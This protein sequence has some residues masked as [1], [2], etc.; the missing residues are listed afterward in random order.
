[1]S[2]SEIHLCIGV[3][4]FGLYCLAVIIAQVVRIWSL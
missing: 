4:I 2:K 1:M 3:G